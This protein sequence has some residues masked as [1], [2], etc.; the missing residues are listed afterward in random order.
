[1]ARRSKTEL[2]KTP[3]QAN[4]MQ[5]RRAKNVER[6]WSAGVLAPSGSP[7]SAMQPATFGHM[8]GQNPLDPPRLVGDSVSFCSGQMSLVWRTKVV[9]ITTR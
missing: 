7:G 3:N 8:P 5:G 6:S 4:Q 9:G 2:A 1:M